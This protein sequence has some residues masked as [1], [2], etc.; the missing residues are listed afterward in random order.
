MKGITAYIVAVAGLLLA[1]GCHK[2]TSVSGVMGYARYY[3]MVSRME[4]FTPDTPCA[5]FAAL[6][7][8][9][10]EA[11]NREYSKSWEVDYSGVSI[12][13]ALDLADQEAFMGFE[14]AYFNLYKAGEE[15]AQKVADSYLGAGAFCYEYA[16]VVARNIVL[17][18]SYG[19]KFE[20]DASK[21]LGQ[22]AVAGQAGAAGIGEIDLEDITDGR[23]VRAAA[24]APQ[25]S[26]VVEQTVTL[27]G[28][29]L[30]QWRGEQFAE[31]V[32]ADG[33]VT[34]TLNL[35]NSILA[36]LADGTWYYTIKGRTAA[37]NKRICIEVPFTLKL[38]N[39]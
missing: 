21:V 2:D 20:Y 12:E 27:Y 26:D 36:T 19:V 37:D 34:L 13:T 8:A 11:L 1:V 16:A 23:V 18:R 9:S 3:G 32:L 38:Q 33:E 39:Q 35:S 25:Y 5:T 10:V 22:V 17:Y 15:F 14:A 30:A 4:H 29:D 24:V 28:P 31:G 6:A 7:S